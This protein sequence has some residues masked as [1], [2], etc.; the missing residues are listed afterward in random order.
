MTEQ[1]VVATAG[2][3]DHGKSALVQA[4]TGTETDRWAE[5]RE[6]GLTIDL[7]FA[8]MSLP[9]GR[10][11]SFVD[12]PGHERFVGNMLAGLGP[13]PVVCLVVAA[14][15]GW[16]AQTSEHRDAIKALEISAGVVVISR[17]DLAP[18]NI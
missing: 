6:R 1:F 16:Q 17:L 13:A 4:L 2:H 9:S 10:S 14:D 18:D 3:V 7:G 12:V 8:E 5:E 15:E 11:V